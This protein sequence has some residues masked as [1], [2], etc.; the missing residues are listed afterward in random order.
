VTVPK[1]SLTRR[2]YHEVIGYA[3]ALR[4]F[5]AESATAFDYLVTEFEFRP[6]VFEETGYGA[7]C[8]FEKDTT[9]VE[10][11]LDWSEELI[12]PYVRLG[13]RSEAGRVIGPP[14]ILFDAIMIHKS[15]RPKKQSKVLKNERMRETLHEYA[16]AL[17]ADA[18]KRF[19]ATFVN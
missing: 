5:R 18:R 1:E 14:G 2:A 10:I 17:R 6:P 19:A 4:R 11:H 9:V 12:L 8:R 13:L 7:L 15:E 16:R 3:G